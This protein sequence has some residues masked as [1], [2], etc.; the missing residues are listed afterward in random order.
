MDGQYIP[1]RSF[2]NI[3][4]QARATLHARAYAREIFHA[5]RDEGTLRITRPQEADLI[6]LVG[7][8]GFLLHSIRKYGHLGIPFLGIFFGNLGFHMNPVLR[9]EELVSKLIDWGS[10][11]N[12]NP[13]PRLEVCYEL[14]GPHTPEETVYAFNEMR[15]ISMHGTQALRLSLE[16]DDEPFNIFSGDGLLI[17]TPQGTTGYAINAQGSGI[18]PKVPCQIIVP[19][20]AQIAWVY[21]SLM[22][23]WICLGSTPVTIRVLDQK[24]RPAQLI[25]DNADRPIVRVAAV[26][27]RL[28]EQKTYLLELSDP[29]YRMNYWAK[30][31]DKIIGPPRDT[32]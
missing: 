8:D 5:L 20:H 9:P 19:L 31:A 24:Q 7:G 18:E 1:L 16:I 26:R 11:F 13:Y 21:R 14:D 32:A 17:S 27:T 2:Q 23:P 12:V 30:V 28:A 29:K 25:H 22:V 3:A 6:I 4:V 10:H 15:I